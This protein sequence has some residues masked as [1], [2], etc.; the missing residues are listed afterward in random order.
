MKKRLMKITVCVMALMMAA[1]FAMPN[2][3]FAADS[4]GKPKATNVSYVYDNG[5]KVGIKSFGIGPFSYVNMS[6]DAKLNPDRKQTMKLDD[7][8]LNRIAKQKIFPTW[9]YLAEGIFRDQ[10]SQLVTIEGSGMMSSSKDAK[11]SFDRHFNTGRKDVSNPYSSENW[12]VSNLGAALGGESVTKGT[13]CNDEVRTTGIQAIG[14]LKDART[15]MGQALRDCSDD[16]DVS[17]DEFLGN[18]HAKTDYKFRLPDLNDDKSGAGFCNIVTCVNRA[19]GSGDY[20]YVT[21]GVAVYDFDVNPVAA[22]NLE[23][24]KAVDGYDSIADAA[25]AEAPGVSYSNEERSAEDVKTDMINRTAKE[26]TN[27]AGLEQSITEEISETDEESSEWGMDEE[28]GSEMSFGEDSDFFKIS[29]HYNH[30]FHQLW[31]TTKSKTQ[32]TSDTKTKTITSELEL[33]PHTRAII[34]QKINKS[35]AKEEYNQPVILSYKV[36]VFAMSGDYFN[37]WCGG[38]EP[39]RYDKQWM[40]VIFDGSDA[41]ESSG[42][43]AISSLY[44]RAIVNRDTGSYDG[45]HGK[46]NVWCD[47][48][49]WNKSSKIN[50]ENIETEINT[51]NTNYS[52]NGRNKLLNISKKAMT[53][54]DMSTELLLAEKA[55]VFNVNQSSMQTDLKKIV[56]LYNLDSITIDEGPKS[57][58]VNSRYRF[59]LQKVEVGGYSRDGVPF[60]NFQDWWGK[61]VPCDEEGDPLEAYRTPVEEGSEEYV[62]DNS[63]L[64]RTAVLNGET[65]PD[66]QVRLCT[67]ADTSVM[68]N[69][70]WVEVGPQFDGTHQSEYY[71]T[72]VLNKDLDIITE[73]SGEHPRNPEGER[74]M[75]LV[76]KD[77][78]ERA[79]LK[80]N[81]STDYSRAHSIEVGGSWTGSYKDQL[82][83][84]KELDTKV[85]DS[86]DVEQP[87]PVFWEAKE[88]SGI[89]IPENMKY[90]VNYGGAAL[91]YSQEDDGQMITFDR[92][93]TYHIRACCTAFTSEESTVG[94]LIPGT[95]NLRKLRSEWITIE[96]RSEPVLSE[97]NFSQ[98]ELTDRLTKT[99]Q[100]AEFDLG[101][102]LHFY[103]QYGDEWTSEEMIKPK[104]A[105]NTIETKS[106]IAKVETLAVNGNARTDFTVSG[107]T[108]TLASP[109]PANANV[110]VIYD[111]K[112]DVSYSLSGD[113][114]GARLN[115]GK[116]TLT[117]TGAG[118]YTVTAHVDGLGDRQ[119]RVVVDEDRWLDYIEFETPPVGNKDLQL[120]EPGDEIRIDN[121]KDC[122]HGYDQ[123]DVE[124]TGEM[125][126]ISFRVVGDNVNGT[127]RGG[128]FFAS[129][130]GLYTIEA[131]AEG[132]EID[133]IQLEVTEKEYLIIDTVDP[134]PIKISNPGETAEIELD[135][136]VEPRT[137]FGTPWKGNVPGLRFELEAPV[138]GAYIRNDS[139]EG[140]VFVATQPGTYTVSVT[141]KKPNSSG[142][143]GRPIDDIIIEVVQE[144][145]P[146]RLELD[147]SGIEE[148]RKQLS[149][150]NP[151]LTVDL[152]DY[153]S[154]YDQFGELIRPEDRIDLPATTYD[155]TGTAESNGAASIEGSTLTISA[156]GSYTVVAMSTGLTNTAMQTIHVTDSRKVTVT[157]DYQRGGGD[158]D[159]G[160]FEVLRG[161]TLD[162]ENPILKDPEWAGHS[163]VAWIMDVDG[164]VCA[165][166][167]E[168]SLRPVFGDREG[169]AKLTAV[170]SMAE[171]YSSDE[172]FMVK[173]VA[174]KADSYFD[175]PES[176]DKEKAAKEEALLD[177]RGDVDD[178][179]QMDRERQ[180][181]KAPLIDLLKEMMTETS[182]SE[183]NDAILALDSDA[184]WAGA[185]ITYD[186]KPTADD[187]GAGMEVT[188]TRTCSHCD[189]HVLTETKTA[190]LEGQ[191][192]EDCTYTRTYRSGSFDHEFFEEQTKDVVVVDH[193]PKYIPDIPATCQKDG[194]VSCYWCTACEKYF[195]DEAC[196][197]ELTEGEV[198]ITKDPSK[199]FW[200]VWEY[201]EPDAQGN[202]TNTRRCQNEGC[203]ETETNTYKASHEKHELKY[204]D[205][206][207]ASCNE[208]GRYGIRAHWECSVCNRCFTD[209]EGLTEINPN[210]LIIE[211]KDHE[212]YH[213]ENLEPSCDTYGIKELW[214]CENCYA[215]F[216]DPEAKTELSYEQIEKHFLAPLE[217]QLGEPEYS[218]NAGKATQTI[219]CTRCGEAFTEEAPYSTKITK[220]AGCDEAGL[221]IQTADFHGN[222]ISQE[223]DIAPTGHSWGAWESIDADGHRRVCEKNAAHIDV[224]PHRWDDGEVTKAATTTAT[225]I[226]TFTCLD[227]GETREEVIPKVVPGK[228]SIGN[229]AVT[230]PKQ[231]YNG[232]ARTPAPTVKV[233]GVTLKQGTD[234]EIAYK[235]NVKAG[236]ANLTITGKGKY[237][238]S[239]SKNFTIAKAA[240]PMAVKAKKPVV[241][242]KRVKKK[243]QTIAAKKAFAVSKAKGKVTYKKIKGNKKITVSAKGKVTVKKKIK[244]GTYKIKVKVRAKGNAN[245]KAGSR[246]VTLKI[247]V[248]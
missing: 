90:R 143:Y 93:G 180:Q 69:N 193:D 223:F 173:A 202:I 34:S 24:I 82:N 171:G 219:K 220:L 113:G 235:N 157:Y 154:Y 18:G 123:H 58:E 110:M 183:L 161:S 17:V 142:A 177:I 237:T 189:K 94:T 225:G 127:V 240:Q 169:K 198:V 47:K 210:D 79:I 105:T 96:A 4:K 166:F 134:D 245:Y 149:E 91:D 14:S 230:I 35:T 205:E 19:G 108:I 50:W 216:D 99:K 126:K 33:P 107:N 23:Y 55:A 144:R 135:R 182:Y 36:A 226:R 218:W 242:Y 125:P 75:S 109:V 59:P 31:S 186:W 147:L 211:P 131:S 52:P 188:A 153:T 45:A 187:Q 231:V 138:A 206:V 172:W 221:K 164:E 22:S 1:T 162:P 73:E 248:K 115:R 77:N 201:G 103:D 224:Q 61:W 151:S 133:P 12:S 70:Q 38:I 158:D 213:I 95:S 92:E 128:S 174:E 214:V 247:R 244:K 106:P 175:L 234:F 97:M 57:Y 67:S 62:A 121:L 25:E 63:K 83:P 54:S 130:P 192:V 119:I 184:H 40:S 15:M 146:T 148:Q 7:A 11:Q 229:A 2:V 167:D 137:Q 21:F 28:V 43:K 100:I 112:I 204:V 85:Y 239:I 98:E 227:C 176:T 122:I 71:L 102:Y 196:E 81:V 42:C 165:Y 233:N 195:E 13:T 209:E 243:K 78:V 86:E 72:W 246:T 60:H 132:Y 88:A 101:S 145:R 139:S 181:G 232:K 140:P 141:E 65:D 29:F 150:D 116:G 49:A 27:S 53:L 238:G 163:F 37:G 124:W 64:G 68:S 10:A 74:G 87:V 170:W 207:P 26:I 129:A 118:E 6:Q 5:K 114:D 8:T 194:N 199:H 160:T 215:S 16:N 44:N 80:L 117:V 179:K 20:D 185:A 76:E 168:P 200:G 30:T 48:D 152:K 104:T 208:N 89:N 120:L 3:A 111:P 228:T 212:L 32:T 84:Y 9:G 136:Q 217:H 197:K 159:T 241:K 51:D 155:L 191:T 178:L 190:T 156:A 222:V 46:Y 66:K 41:K 39:G 203:T 236:T 56:P